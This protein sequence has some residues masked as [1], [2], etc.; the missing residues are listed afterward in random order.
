[1]NDNVEN[2]TQDKNM[3]KGK[4]EQ[5]FYRVGKQKLKSNK[6]LN[7]T[8]TILYINLII[9]AW[10][11]S[12]KILN[13]VN[14]DSSFQFYWLVKIIVNA[15]GIIVVWVLHRG[16]IILL[17]MVGRPIDAEETEEILEDNGFVTQKGD[18]PLL[19]EKHKD[20]TKEDSTEYVFYNRGI[21][22][23]KWKFNDFENWLDGYIT[24]LDY[25]KGTRKKTV[26]RITPTEKYE[27]FILTTKN[28]KMTQKPRHTLIC[29]ESGS[30]KSFRSFDTSLSVCQKSKYKYH[31]CRRKSRRLRAI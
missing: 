6:I 19:L 26:I 9:L 5:I 16:L 24:Y 18:T 28:N 22:L 17:G 11:H 30:G 25:A 10:L 4:N 13:L 15:I 2:K 12:W 23:D 8:S 27:P 20:K 29:G 7:I 3:Q 21:S 14:Y 31:T 1:M